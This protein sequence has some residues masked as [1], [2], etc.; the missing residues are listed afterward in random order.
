MR[1][2]GSDI[3]AAELEVLGSLW[4]LGS[5]TVR[6]VLEDLREQGRSLAYTTVLTLL[7]RLESR[8]YVL[9]SRKSAAHVYRPRISRKKVVADRLGSLVRQLG[10]GEATPLIL[11]LV[12]SHKLSK[13]DLQ[14]LR[15]LLDRLEAEGR[16]GSPDEE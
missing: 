12:E 1:R 6:E 13:R 5:A 3:P 4:R 11:Q 7:G 9:C 15:R 16:S 10:E 8:G 14:Q 2:D